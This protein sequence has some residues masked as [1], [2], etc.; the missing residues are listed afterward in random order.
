MSVFVCVCVCVCVCVRAR[1][2]AALGIQHATRTCHNII[3]G[4]PGSKTFFHGTTFETK[5]LLNTKLRFDFLYNFC[6]K[7][8]NSKN[9]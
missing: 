3:H 6:L 4:L 8:F 5:K 1:A 7:L 9:N 2:R